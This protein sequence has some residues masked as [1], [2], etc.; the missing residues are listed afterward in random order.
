MQWHVEV[1]NVGG[2]KYSHSVSQSV[3]CLQPGSNPRCRSF[4][5]KEHVID[6]ACSRE[7]DVD[8]AQ[9]LVLSVHHAS[10]AFPL[11]AGA[12][13]IVRIDVG[14]GHDDASWSSKLLS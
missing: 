13:G 2:D 9:A 5:A 7:L 14:I 4:V 1:I 11:F 10:S 8:K 3:S 6:R 12:R